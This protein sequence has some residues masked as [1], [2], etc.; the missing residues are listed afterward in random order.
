MKL[1]VAVHRVAVA[2]LLV[3]AAMS[4]AGTNRMVSPLLRIASIFLYGLPIWGL[5]TFKIWT[6]PK[7]WGLGVGIFLFAMLGF[8]I[9]LWNLA[10][11][12]P[13]PHRGPI[14]TSLSGFVIDETPLAV[15][16]I[17]CLLLRWLYPEDS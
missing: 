15:T 10:V 7:S 17:C 1:H 9:Y 5:L 4:I 6:R 16:A 11:A 8:Q 2:G 3:L 13:P 14:D 12:H